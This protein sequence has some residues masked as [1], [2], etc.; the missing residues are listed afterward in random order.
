ML[1][2]LGVLSLAQ[3]ARAESHT[4]RY[5]VGTSSPAAVA[6]A[7]TAATSVGHV[8]DFG[9]IGQ[10]VSGRFTQEALRGL[11]RRPDVRYVERDFPVEAFGIDA[12]DTEYGNAWGVDRVDA[13]KVHTPNASIQ[14]GAGVHIAIIDTGIDSDHEDLAANLGEGV[15]F[16][17]ADGV[18]RDTWED[19]RG[20]GTHCAGIAGAIRNAKGVVGTGPN[21]V[22]HA[23][24]TLDS[25]GTGYS[26]DSARGITYAADKGWH[27]ASLSLGSKSPSSASADAC[28]YAYRKGVLLVAA[29][30]ND[31]PDDGTVRYPAAFSEVIAVSATTKTD[32]LR[33][34]SSRGSEIELAAPGSSINSTTFDGG[35]GLKSG[36][37]MACPHVSG[38]GGVLRA[39]GKTNVQARDLLGR[40]AE[41][42]GLP[43]N[44][45]GKGLLDVEA[46]VLA[47]GGSNEDPAPAPDPGDGGA[48]AIPTIDVFDVTE[49]SA[50]GPH[51]EFVVTWSGSD[52]DG[53]LHTVITELYNGAN[54]LLSSAM[55]G[56][57][58]STASGSSALQAKN[59]NGK[60][61]TFTVKLIVID[62]A[63]NAVTASKTVTEDRK[64]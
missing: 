43:A 60:G 10:A 35:Y 12:T 46:A 63:E 49:R 56:I 26:S 2:Y 44:E 55:T 16:L 21:V 58:G 47:A 61:N 15:A 23:I 6:A 14:T 62:A 18:A 1:S 7:R 17:N 31:G 25:T 34:S 37:S 38:A 50:K 45:Q 36:T 42:V 19:D 32:T 5:I 4:E 29:A 13:E 51:A 53:D 8:L 20:H 54:G 52:V 9:S 30:G 48:N 40:S 11:E 33:T 41:D 39:M 3:V 57:S 27:V 22:L 28:K 59:E 64:R 24:K